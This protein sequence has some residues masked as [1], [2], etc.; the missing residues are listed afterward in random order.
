MTDVHLPILRL[1]ARRRQEELDDHDG[2]GHAGDAASAG[3]RSDLKQAAGRTRA[4]VAAAEA[5]RRYPQ[6]VRGP[7]RQD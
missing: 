6:A 3:R 4:N 2:A 5:R 7:T 1:L